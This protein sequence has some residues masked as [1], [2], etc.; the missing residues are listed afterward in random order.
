MK[1]LPKIAKNRSRFKANPIPEE[2]L[3]ISNS[4]NIYIENIVSC[5]IH[6]DIN[7]G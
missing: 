1:K 3:Q 4:K 6:I 2:S 5:T 7:I